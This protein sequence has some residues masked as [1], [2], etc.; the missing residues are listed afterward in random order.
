MDIVVARRCAE[1]PAILRQISLRERRHDAA[2]A[3]VRDLEHD[4]LADPKFSPDPLTLHELDV[5]VVG[6]HNDVG[7]EAPDLEAALRIQLTEPG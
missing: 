6:T 7:P 5:I 3:V 4:L 1:D 2:R